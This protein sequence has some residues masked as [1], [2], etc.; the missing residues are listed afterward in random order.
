MSDFEKELAALINKYSREN[1]SNTPD[2]ILAT[3]L[4][5][6]LDVFNGAIRQ[7]ES[8]YGRSDSPFDKALAGIDC[9]KDHGTWYIGL[10]MQQL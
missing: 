1:E 9:F 3:F 10:H 2:F 8:W 5:G 6:C 4:R 7:R